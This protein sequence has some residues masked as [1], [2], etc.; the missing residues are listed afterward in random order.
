ML[1]SNLFDFAENNVW[2]IKKLKSFNWWLTL[3]SQK[4]FF[5]WHLLCR[6][7]VGTA[8]CLGKCDGLKQKGLKNVARTGWLFA[9]QHITIKNCLFMP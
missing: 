9:E 2:E 8:Q 4:K 6:M 3:A 1:A 5:F 7:L